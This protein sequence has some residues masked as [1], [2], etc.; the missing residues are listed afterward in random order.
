MAPVAAVVLG[1][2]TALV[3]GVLRDVVVREAVLV[4]PDSELYAILTVIGALA[5]AVAWSPDMHDPVLGDGLPSASS[6]WS[7]L[8]RSAR[9]AALT[10]PR[11][12]LTSSLV[13]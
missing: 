13:R 5:V 4:R 11:M 9:V 6:P 7:T 10:P 3:G 1:V 8:A 2:T 12:P